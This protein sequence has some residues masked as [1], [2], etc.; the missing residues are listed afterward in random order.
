M[1]LPTTPP[2]VDCVFGLI[3]GTYACFFGKEKLPSYF[4]ENKISAYSDGFFRLNMPGVHFNNSNWKY[5]LG[6]IRIWSIVMLLAGPIV[7]LV[8]CLCYERLDWVSTFVG[9]SVVSGVGILVTIFVPI[10]Y[11]AIKFE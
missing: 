3:F 4:D 6:W 11:L 8:A 1:K 9:S 2:T 7:W 10:Y 5:I